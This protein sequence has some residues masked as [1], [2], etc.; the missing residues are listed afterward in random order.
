MLTCT[1]IALLALVLCVLAMQS[2]YVAAWHGAGTARRMTN[3]LM[4]MDYKVRVINKKKNAD[5]TITVPKGQIILDAGEQQGFSAIPYSCR[6]GSCSSCLGKLISGTVDQ[7]SQI[8]LDDDKVRGIHTT[9]LT[10]C[11]LCSCSKSDSVL[12]D[13]QKH[14]FINTSDSKHTTCL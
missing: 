13:T 6:A 12:D 8:F 7:S 14:A 9:K 1:K 10:V 5:V 3:R 2:S 4:S 11:V